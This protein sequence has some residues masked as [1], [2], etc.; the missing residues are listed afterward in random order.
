MK[1][2]L[3]KLCIATRFAMVS[4]RSNYSVM[5]WHIFEISNT[6]Y[7]V[8]KNMNIHFSLLSLPIF[9]LRRNT[10][11]ARS[12]KPDTLNSLLPTK[13]I[14]KK[15]KEIHG[16]SN[17]MESQY[18]HSF[19]CVCRQHLNTNRP[20]QSNSGNLCSACNIIDSRLQGRIFLY[21][22]CYSLMKPVSLL[23]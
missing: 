20:L 12:L 18:F 19:S 6:Y 17:I 22:D 23:W 7:I 16:T 9:L 2:K 13:N 15:N 14:E 1:I 8:Q 4:G 11:I 5:S 3:P 21:E 10:I